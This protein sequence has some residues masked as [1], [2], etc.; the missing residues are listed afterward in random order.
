MSKLSSVR[1]NLCQNIEFGKYESALSHITNWVKSWC[2]LI[3]LWGRGD[4][5]VIETFYHAHVV[6]SILG[7]VFDC[8]PSNRHIN[9]YVCMYINIYIYQLVSVMAGGLFELQPV[10]FLYTSLDYWAGKCCCYHCCLFCT[11]EQWLLHQIGFKC[12]ILENSYILII[13]V[14]NL[15]SHIPCSS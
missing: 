13:I 1:F 9:V 15:L 2:E 11:L 10:L 6:K 14:Y 8:W 5:M 3:K 12:P 7:T 4:F